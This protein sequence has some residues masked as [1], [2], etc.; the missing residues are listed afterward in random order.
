MICCGGE[1]GYG[2]D[3][4]IQILMVWGV[5]YCAVYT[6]ILKRFIAISY[7]IILYVM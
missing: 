2:G 5:F 7:I 6:V 3:L 4:V 1:K